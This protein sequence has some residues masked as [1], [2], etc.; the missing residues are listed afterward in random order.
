MSF[1]RDANSKAVV[2]TTSWDDGHACDL[3]LADLLGSRGLPGTFY[4]TSGSLG[5]ASALSAADVR[6]LA[7]AG[8]EIGAHTVTHPV[9][10]DLSAD[11]VFREAMESKDTLEEILGKEVCS[12]AYPKGRS[13]PRVAEQ[14]KRAGYRCARGLRMLSLSCDFPA[15][16]MPVSIQAYPHP[17]SS[18]CRNL[19]R[20]GE[21]L[22]LVKASASFYSKNWVQLGKALFDQAVREGGAWH[23]LGHSWET[24]K[25]EGWS[26]LEEMLDYVSGHKGV[27][28]LSNG[29]LARFVGS[30]NGSP[31]AA[32]GPQR[33]EHFSSEERDSIKDGR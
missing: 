20:R 11:E 22:A 4:V 8:F 32:G 29:G 31:I 12:F 10:T 14:V 26:E 33:S 2:V 30:P 7:N 9:L 5:Q 1:Q 21:V 23:L 28:Y 13:N 6:G 27:H 24:E 18:Y 17:W 16:D 3:K 25:L 15:F 19:L